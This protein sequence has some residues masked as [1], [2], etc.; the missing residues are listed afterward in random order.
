MRPILLAA[1]AAALLVPMP[2]AAQ[3]LEGDLEGLRVDLL[4]RMVEER[5]FPGMAFFC[6]GL[7]GATTPVEDPSPD[8]MER[9]RERVHLLPIFESRKPAIRPFSECAAEAYAQPPDPANRG[10]PMIL[11]QLSLGPDGETASSSG[12]AGLGAGEIFDCRLNRTADGWT[13]HACGVFHE[14]YGQFQIKTVPLEA[15]GRR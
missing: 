3:G 8:V 10:Q 14:H 15:G 9:V 5:G 13:T 11:T 6:L 12:H 7:G 2:A 1:C 4:S